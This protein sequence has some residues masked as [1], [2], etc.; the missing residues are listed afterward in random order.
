MAN[1]V[2]APEA[3]EDVFQIWLY[4]LWE[5][6]RETADRIEGEITEAFS[7]LTTMPGKG[8]R[9]PDLTRH[10]VLFYSIYQYMVVYRTGTPLEIIA[11]LHGRRNVKRILKERL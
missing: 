1:F 8:H 9:R 6:G 5:A 3:E 2:V 7:R 11:V 10:N 4:L